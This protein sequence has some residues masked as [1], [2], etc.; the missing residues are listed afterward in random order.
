VSRRPPR[1]AGRETGSGRAS[2]PRQ[3]ARTAGSSTGKRS[4]MASGGGRDLGVVALEGAL[5]PERKGVPADAARTVESARSQGPERTVTP[6]TRGR[7]AHG[8]RAP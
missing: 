8:D 7:H 6:S 3:A 4:R 2:T 1:A 5:E